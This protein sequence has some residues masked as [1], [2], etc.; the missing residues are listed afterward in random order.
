M[1]FKK[2][3]RLIKG[4]KITQMP[5]DF[6]VNQ[7]KDVQIARIKLE[8]SCFKASIKVPRVKHIFLFTLLFF[9]LNSN[10]DCFIIASLKQPYVTLFCLFVFLYS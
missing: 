1:N 6:R 8:H 5:A 10:E 7:Y 2:K 9:F 4:V 3:S